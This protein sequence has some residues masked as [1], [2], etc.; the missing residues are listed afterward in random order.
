[1]R[2]HDDPG[3]HP[4]EELLDDELLEDEL[5]EDELLE[6]LEDELLGGGHSPQTPSIRHPQKYCLGHPFG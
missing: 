4:E 2:E 1:M 5:L 6:L 3:S